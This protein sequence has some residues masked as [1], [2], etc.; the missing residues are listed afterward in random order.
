MNAL[1]FQK[2][3]QQTENYNSLE[4]VS[5]CCIVLWN[6]GV[7]YL[8]NY[9]IQYM[10]PFMIHS[11]FVNGTLILTHTSIML[12]TRLNKQI[13]NIGML[14]FIKFYNKSKSIYIGTAYF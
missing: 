4:Q 14:Y 3:S 6:N 2:L 12:M 10:L 1:L 5:I 8:A 11:P 13:E 7:Y 9:L